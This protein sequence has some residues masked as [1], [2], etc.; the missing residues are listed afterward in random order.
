M[1]R[2]LSY[3]AEGFVTGLTAQLDWIYDRQ[4]QL[5]WHEYVGEKV[6]GRD[7]DVRERRML[8]AEALFRR[9]PVPKNGISHL[10]TRLAELYAV[11]GVKTMARDLRELVD[12]GL[13]R[14]TPTGFVADT[15]ALLSLLPLVV[16][17]AGI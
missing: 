2:F 11:C 17:P 15:D 10:T 3:C 1:T 14:A 9:E 5:T 16:P 6:T 13:L 12:S 7:P 8:I 4:F